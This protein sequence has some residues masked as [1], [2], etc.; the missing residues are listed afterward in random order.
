MEPSTLPLKFLDE[1]DTI[2]RKRWQTLMAVDNMV[3]NIVNILRE[4]KLL[5]KTFIFY[6]SD[7]GFHLGIVFLVIDCE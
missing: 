4:K 1:M 2:H 5:E 7:N 6:T 3:E